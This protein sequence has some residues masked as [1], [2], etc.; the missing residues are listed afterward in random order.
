MDTSQS[1]RG[2]RGGHLPYPSV[3]PRNDGSLMRF[4]VKGN[5]T[6]QIGDETSLARPNGRDWP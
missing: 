6:N 2:T 4:E 3:C 5:R 1:N